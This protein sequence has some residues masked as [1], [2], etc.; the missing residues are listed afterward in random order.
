M[1]TAPQD[2]V[3]DAYLAS[4]GF[5]VLRVWNSDVMLRLDEVLEQIAATLR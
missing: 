2:A 4:A 1:R 3:R 5:R